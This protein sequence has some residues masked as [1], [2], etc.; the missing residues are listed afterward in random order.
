[1]F[2]QLKP[3]DERD[4]T[5]DQ[6]IQ[7]LRPKVAQVEGA[8]FFMQSG[9]DI[10]VGGRLSR[11][12]YQYTLTDTDSDELNHWAPI[13]EAAMQKLPELQD[14]ASDQQIAA[15]HIG[16]RDRP[17]R[18]LAARASRCRWST[19]RCTTR[20][21]SARSRRCTPR[22][23]STRSS[24]SVKPEFQND[25]TALSKIYVPGRERRA[26]A[27]QHASPIH[28]T[29]VEP[30]LVSHQGQ[31]PAVTLSFN[32]APGRRDRPGGRQD[33]RDWSASCACRRPSTARSRAPRRPSR[34]RCNRRRC[35]SPPRSW[36][37]TSCWACSTRATSTRSR[38]C[39]RCPRPA[40]ARCWR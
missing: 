33:P 18:R 1:M 21:A 2:I 17:R 8:K 25:P 15:P 20:S 3:H 35:S 24:S 10:S 32:L 7:R 13:V 9:Q 30:L 26:G 37:S 11:T 29:S 27:A 4:V 6:V 31:F 34:P 38:S 39:R 23:T 14:V 40:S 5:S 22:P 28:K 12:Q 36:S 19:R 16:D